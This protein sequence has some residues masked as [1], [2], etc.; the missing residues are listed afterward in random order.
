MIKVVLKLDLHDDRG[1]QKALKAVSSLQGVES[2]SMDMKDNKLT[3]IGD[4]DPV[5][6]I[7]K[8]RKHWPNAD[9]LTVGPAKEEKP[10]APAAPPAPPKTPD[11]LNE[12]ILKWYQ[13]NGYPS[14]APYYRVYSVEENP[15]SCVIS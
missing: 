15:N 7:A 5:G 13:K 4:V 1:K 3:V 14:Y 9:I 8:L 2:I 11:E 6:V 12:E 10:A